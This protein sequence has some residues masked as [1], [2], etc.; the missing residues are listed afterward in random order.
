MVLDLV[1]LEVLETS[2]DQ[3]VAIT[4]SQAQPFSE[5]PAVWVEAEPHNLQQQ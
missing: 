5:P 4:Y 3:R 1:V 2:Q